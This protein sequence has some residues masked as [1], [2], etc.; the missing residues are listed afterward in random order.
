MTRSRLL[1]LGISA[2]AI[3][4]VAVATPRLTALPPPAIA[5]VRLPPGFS[6][7][8]YADR[9]DGARQMT[10]SPSGTLYVGSREGRV[11]A[12]PDRDGDGRGDEVLVVARDLAGPHGVAFRDGA[13]YV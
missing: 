6:I 11:Y 7:T 5:G 4:G 8:V 9:L 3:A 10:M 1:T 13:L 2:A 12:V